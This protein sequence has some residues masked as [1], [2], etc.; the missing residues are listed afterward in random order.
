MLTII[1]ELGLR[2]T[3]EKAAKGHIRDEL[4]NF[5]RQGYI[6]PHEEDDNLGMGQSN[7][8]TSP[9]KKK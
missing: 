4:W 9:K 8:Q 1:E 2:D 6:I 3:Q 7:A 5:A